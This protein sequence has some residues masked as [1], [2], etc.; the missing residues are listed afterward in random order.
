[1]PTHHVG[2]RV[3][4]SKSRLFEGLGLLALEI[5]EQAQH[6]DGNLC[7]VVPEFTTFQYSEMKQACVV[8]VCYREGEKKLLSSFVIVRKQKKNYLVLR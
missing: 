5:F 6:K 3:S 1:M 4:P 2:R 7:G 8:I